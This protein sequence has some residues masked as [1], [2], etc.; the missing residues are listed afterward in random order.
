MD[1]LTAL[2]AGLLA[3]WGV[4]LPLGAVAA[5]LLQEGMTRGFAQGWTAGVAVGAVDVAYCAVAVAAGASAGAVVA[6]Y[7]PWPAVVGG[8]ALVAFALVGARRSWAPPRTAPVD[9]EGDPGPGS[10]WRRFALFVGLT[11]LNPATLVYF[12]ALT[13][14]VSPTSSTATAVAFVGGV[15]IASISWQVALVAVGATV[16]GRVTPRARHVT[17]LVGHGIV[18]ALGVAMVVRALV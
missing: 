7:A 14:A 10:R 2:G 13:V 17:T 1:I 16:R 4:A 12:A 18:A 5:L 3:G 15:G 9:T 8:V 6:R 11:A